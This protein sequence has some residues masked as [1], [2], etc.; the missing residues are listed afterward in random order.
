MKTSKVLIFPT[1]LSMIVVSRISNSR[2]PSIMHENLRNDDLVKKEAHDLEACNLQLFSFELLKMGLL[3]HQFYAQIW[4]KIRSKMRE[5]E[6]AQAKLHP[7]KE[8]FKLKKEQL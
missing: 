7:D 5:R 8:I 2:S 6:N 4:T 3:G 1:V